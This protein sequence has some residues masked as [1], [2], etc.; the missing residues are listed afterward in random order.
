M[1]AETRRNQDDTDSMNTI[2]LRRRSPLKFFLLVFA[3]SLPFLLAGPLVGYRLVP[4]VPVTALIVV[5][6]PATAAIIL[7]YRES[8]TAGVR[9]LLKRSFD[10]KR[11]KAKIWYAPILLLMPGVTI[12]SYGWMRW[13]GVPLPIPQVPVVAT[14]V[15]SLAIFILALGEELG[16]SGY[17]ID[18]MQD[19][20]GALPASILLGLACALWHILPLVQV[21]RS[22]AWIAWWCLGTVAARV[23]MV[24]LYNNTG[25]S[26]FAMAVFHTT[27]NVTWQ[28]FPIRGSYWDPRVNGVIMAIAAVVVVGVWGPRTLAGYRKD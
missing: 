10:Y 15:M 22:P 7:V 19:R 3:L 20:W 16:W 14:L 17:A 2:P 21:H 4:G 25:K 23:L 6:C 26:V 11:I 27:I 1:P 18:P 9:D 24:W 5:F 28:L 13:I 8:K 12:L